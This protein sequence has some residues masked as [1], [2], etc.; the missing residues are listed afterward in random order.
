MAYALHKQATMRN[1]PYRF[2]NIYSP[3][4][5]LE[6]SEAALKHPLLKELLVALAVDFLTPGDMGYEIQQLFELLEEE[7][8]QALLKARTGT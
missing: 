1:Q 3:K 6:M 2:M 7:K 5:A 4:E 8:Q